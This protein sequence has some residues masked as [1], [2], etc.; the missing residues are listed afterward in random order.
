MKS[1]RPHSIMA[2]FPCCFFFLIDIIIFI[3]VC[4]LGCAGFLLLHVFSPL[5]A[6]RGY[7]AVAVCGLL[8]V[9]AALVGHGL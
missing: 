1:A 9:V 6:S 4:M 8:T 7:S 5:V 2:A 3:Y